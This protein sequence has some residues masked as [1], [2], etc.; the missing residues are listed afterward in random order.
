MGSGVLNDV[1]QL[2]RGMERSFT[3]IRMDH[4]GETIQGLLGGFAKPKDSSE[5]QK[6]SLVC[7]VKQSLQCFNSPNIYADIYK[8]HPYTMCC[9]QVRVNYERN[10]MIG[11]QGRVQLTHV[12][13]N[14][15]R[16]MVV[17]RGTILSYSQDDGAVLHTGTMVVFT[18]ITNQ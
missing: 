3:N 5:R 10:M 15:D 12:P 13:E 4:D 17:P 7:C 11:A 14:E 16:T 2:V 9:F 6:Q 18:L 8:V 1:G